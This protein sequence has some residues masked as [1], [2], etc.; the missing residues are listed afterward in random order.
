MLGGM[1]A[2]GPPAS[3]T[4]AQHTVSFT[5]VGEHLFVVPA[6]VTTVHVVAVAGNGAGASATQGLGA[7]VTADLA[8][9]P[10][11]TLYLEVGGNGSFPV[12]GA[13]GGGDG[14]HGSTFTSLGGGGGGASDVRTTPSLASRVL[15]AGGGG[16][17]PASGTGAGGN[18]GVP[19]GTDGIAG[20]ATLPGHAGTQSQ[21]GTPGPGCG[22]ATAGDLGVGGHGGGTNNPDNA[23]GGGGG[24]LYGGGGGAC[25][26]GGG[27]GSGYFGPGTSNTS[28]T[29][30]NGIPSITLTYTTV[31]A[32]PN[33]RITKATINAARHTATF[34][35]TSVGAASHFQCR[36]KK[37]DH[38]ASYRSCTSPR[39]YRRLTRGRYTFS[40]R[41]IG[42]GG[43]DPTPAAY[44]FRI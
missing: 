23:G 41:A 11:E 36:L 18:S 33:T 10:G 22:S 39:T 5:A 40:V 13:N 1:A 27:G 31:V 44:R 42:P 3:A 38:P 30:G 16:G 35:F 17:A 14:G 37:A 6:G 2:S 28:S 29:A 32:P 43:T 9:T 24:G 26:S 7:A 20:P 21:G 8:V 15:V 34:R 19:T 12:G 4:T 25:D